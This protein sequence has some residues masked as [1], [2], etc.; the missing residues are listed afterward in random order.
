[1]WS[2]VVALKRKCL[3]FTCILKIK[4]IKVGEGEVVQKKGRCKN[5]IRVLIE[6]LLGQKNHLLKYR[7]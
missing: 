4:L 2:R 7:I 3:G 5:V 6:Y 1:M